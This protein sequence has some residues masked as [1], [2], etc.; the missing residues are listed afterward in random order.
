MIGLVFALTVLTG[1]ALVFVAMVRHFLADDPCPRCGSG[2]VESRAELLSEATATDD[3]VLLD[4]LRCRLCGEEERTEVAIPRG[5][6][7]AAFVEHRRA[8]GW[9]SLGGRPVEAGEG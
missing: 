3:G 6:P 1:L 5:T 9:T 4:V 7:Y 8:T 2:Y